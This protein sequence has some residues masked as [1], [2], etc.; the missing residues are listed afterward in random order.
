MNSPMLEKTKNFPIPTESKNDTNKDKFN[1]RRKLKIIDT[2][3]KD[4][5]DKNTYEKEKCKNKFYKI[6]S[7]LGN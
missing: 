5:L 6:I 3:N 7:I 4:K 1:K 2:L